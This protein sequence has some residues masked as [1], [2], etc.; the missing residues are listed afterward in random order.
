VN[1]PRDGRR[2][3]S[4]RLWDELLT[5][6]HGWEL[7]LDELDGWA[8]RERC[9]H[10]LSEDER[11]RHDAFL[12]DRLRRDYLAGTALCRW[13]LSQYGRI[14]PSSWRFALG[15]HGKPKVAAPAPLTSLRFSVTRTN[16]LAICLVTRAGEVGVDAE[17]TS[18]KFDVEPIARHFLSEREQIRFAGLAPHDRAKA[19]FELWVVH[20]AYVKGTG[21]GVG[22]S[23]ERV[24][25]R[26]DRDNRPLPVGRWRFSLRHPSEKHVAA[27]AMRHPHGAPAIPIAWL[28]ADLFQTGVA[29]E[30]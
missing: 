29:V 9:L 15:P 8:L 4:K 11:A 6:V 21:K 18:R 12:T 23:A 25:I 27:A 14:D 20:E 16:G 19:F 13:A 17:D 22:S 30:G 24:R 26:F 3:E 1:E 2:R 28:K 10:W 5:A 7:F